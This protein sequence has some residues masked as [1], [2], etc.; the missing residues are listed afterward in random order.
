MAV[1]AKLIERFSSLGLVVADKTTST[2]NPGRPI[3]S[4]DRVVEI[5][6]DAGSENEITV[7]VNR[8]LES[9]QKAISND[10]SLRKKCHIETFDSH[11]HR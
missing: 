3:W 1:S 8:L 10:P 9:V 2:D 6:F 7:M 5:S 4:S 11:T